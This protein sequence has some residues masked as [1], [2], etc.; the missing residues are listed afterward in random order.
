MKKL[1]QTLLYSIKKN[2]AALQKALRGFS[3]GELQSPE[4]LKQPVL[5][6]LATK[7]RQYSITSQQ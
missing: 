5:A 7:V 6:F 1:E 3:T 4:I 2:L